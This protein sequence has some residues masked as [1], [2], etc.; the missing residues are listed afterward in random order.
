MRFQELPPIMRDLLE[1]E[2]RSM[3]DPW[4]AIDRL[5]HDLQ[6]H[7]LLADPV[8]DDDR[9]FPMVT[10]P[11]VSQAKSRPGPG[12][13]G[14]LPPVVAVRFPVVIENLEE[15]SSQCKSWRQEHP[16]LETPTEK[17][18]PKKPSVTPRG[19]EQIYV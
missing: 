8:Q 13:D 3:F 10:K 11:Y 19:H 5:N 12:P 15:G 17:D 4:P 16:M 2:Q 1:P 14:T 18:I 7:D 6:V 9:I